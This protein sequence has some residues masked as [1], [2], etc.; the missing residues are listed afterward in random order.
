MSWCNSEV[1]SRR[2]VLAAPLALLGLSSCSA[3]P[4]W[5]DADLIQPEVLAH[6]VTG[7]DAEKPVIL[8]VGFPALFRSN[9]IP[10]AILAGP[11]NTPAGLANLKEAVSGLPKTQ[12]I[13]ISCGCCPWVDCPNMKSAFTLLTELGFQRT[14]A[15]MIENNFSKDWVER[16]YP[17]QQR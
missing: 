8:H 1:L 4:E 5:S 7:N 17:T 12:E 13:V 2:A 16:G 9:H 6:R 10:A 14:K 11:G 15:L 3:A